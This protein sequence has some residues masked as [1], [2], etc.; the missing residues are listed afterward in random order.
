MN[1]IETHGLLKVFRTRHGA[2]EAVRGVDLSVETGEVFGF[3]GPNCAGKTTT[4]RMLA[5]LLEPSGGRAT[6]AGHDLFKEPARVR[7]QIGY[8][9]QAG[10]ADE[11]ATGREN[12]LLQGGCTA[13]AKRRRR[14]APRP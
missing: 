5:T 11:G 2:V 13:S 4:L 12:L 7:E 6:V 1:V 14:R 9:S 3:L 8:V 10:G